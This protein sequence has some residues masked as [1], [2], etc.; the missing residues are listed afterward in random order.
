MCLGG[1]IQYSYLGVHSA[2]NE[3][4]NCHCPYTRPQ[5]GELTVH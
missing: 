2:L 1:L 4:Y 3:L 5:K